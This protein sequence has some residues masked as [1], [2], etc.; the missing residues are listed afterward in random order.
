MHVPPQAGRAWRGWHQNVPV[1]PGQ[2]YLL[3]VW[4]KCQ[5]VDGDVRVHAHR[6]QADGQLSADS[7]YAS[8]G[9]SIGGTTDWTLMTGQL[10]MPHDTTVLQLHLTMEH[11]GT[12]WHD[13][14]L[15]IPVSRR[16]VACRTLVRPHRSAG[17]WQVPAVVKVFHDDV[18]DRRLPRFRSQRRATR[19]NR[20]NWPC[21]APKT[22]AWCG[23]S[24][25]RRSGRM[26]F[27][28]E[29][30]EIQVVGYVP[31][32]Y[33]T[34]YYQSESP[35]WHRKVPGR[36]A[37]SDGWPGLWPDPLLPTQPST[38]SRMTQP[39]WITFSIPKRRSGRRLRRPRTSAGWMEQAIAEY[40]LEVRVWDFCLPDQRH[41]A[42]IYDVRLGPGGAALW[43]NRST[44][45][46][47][48]SSA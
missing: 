36:T 15:L 17:V 8:I 13:N 39:I 18:P 16:R 48:R 41:L 35:A 5:D 2:T 21:A 42:A 43:G 24:W 6:R 44:S 9:P 45:C 7:P 4:V 10:T 22:A 1:Q 33:P 27:R 26:D 23:S 38:A 31:I 14:V 25:S 30:A 28:L 12:L 29:H 37:A 46:I 19:A 20:C 40:P 47:R 32:D 3:A 11:T 34:N